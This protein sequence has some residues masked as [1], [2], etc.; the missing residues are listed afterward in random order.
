MILPF[1]PRFASQIA[2]RSIETF[3]RCSCFVIAR[4]HT[5]PH[6]GL[7]IRKIEAEFITDRPLA[8][9][10]LL[11]YAD[12]FEKPRFIRSEHTDDR[13]VANRDNIAYHVNTRVHVKKCECK[14]CRDRKP[15]FRKGATG[16]R[17]GSRRTPMH[18]RA[19][20]ADLASFWQSTS[21]TDTESQDSIADTGSGNTFPKAPP[22]ASR[23]RG[24]DLKSP[25]AGSNRFAVLQVEKSMD[26]D[27]DLGH[28]AESHEQ[29]SDGNSSNHLPQSFCGGAIN[30]P[31]EPPPSYPLAE[32]GA[33]CDSDT[34]SDINPVALD[35]SDL[36][37]DDSDNSSATAP[38]PSPIPNKSIASPTKST[39]LRLHLPRLRILENPTANSNTAAHG[40]SETSEDSSKSMPWKEDDWAERKVLGVRCLSWTRTRVLFG[41]KQGEG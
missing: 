16:R 32:I 13:A 6:P 17:D 4:L 7:A 38:A 12:V 15:A 5:P 10:L 23:L 3:I 14:T 28:T 33:I 39:S 37:D 22:E 2:E 24:G 30:H 21:A 1:L 36:N 31:K 18:T 41:Y 40:T 25:T 34:D 27:D 29:D 8:A 9:D 11:S 35:D 26:E 19:A 20:A